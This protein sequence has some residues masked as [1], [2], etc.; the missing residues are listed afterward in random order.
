M[1]KEKQFYFYQPT[2]AAIKLQGQKAY[3]AV[4]TR[5]S[6]SFIL[7]KQFNWKGYTLNEEFM[8]NYI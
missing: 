1:K 4:C 3:W 5:S 2:K 7:I 6:M 8:Q